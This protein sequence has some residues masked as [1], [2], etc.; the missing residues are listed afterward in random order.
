[1]L[2]EAHIRLPVDRVASKV[3]EAY[4]QTRYLFKIILILSF[5]LLLALSVSLFPLKFF[6]NFW[7]VY[8]V[9]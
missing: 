6:V 9:F 4:V 3:N 2:P 5:H 7:V 1:M 8:V